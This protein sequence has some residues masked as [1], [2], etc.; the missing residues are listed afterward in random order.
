MYTAQKSVTF[1]DLRDGLGFL[2]CVLPGPRVASE[3]LLALL[4]RESSVELTGVLNHLPEGEASSWQVSGRG[5]LSTE[6]CSPWNLQVLIGH[7]MGKF[8]FPISLK[9]FYCGTTSSSV[10][11]CQIPPWK[12]ALGVQFYRLGLISHPNSSS[13]SS[14]NTESD[15]GSCQV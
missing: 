12:A 14:P 13:S 10:T 2:P 1:V 7:K 11:G 15:T 6:M 4:L 8:P 3:A 5:S 9:I